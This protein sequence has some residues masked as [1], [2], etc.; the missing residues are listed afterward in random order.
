MSDATINF[1]GNIML[2]SVKMQFSCNKEI[3]GV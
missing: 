2:E 3:L 1:C